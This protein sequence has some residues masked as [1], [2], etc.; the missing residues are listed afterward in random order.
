[1]NL[2]DRAKGRITPGIFRIPGTSTRV[3]SL[4]KFYAQKWERP[5]KTSVKDQKA[6]QGTLLP[7][8]S[9]PSIHDVASAFKKL[10]SG[11][12]GGIL[13]SVELFNTINDI[14]RHVPAASD[15]SQLEHQIDQARL[16]ALALT[17]SQAKERVSVICAVF[18]L[19]TMVAHETA[20]AT[21]LAGNGQQLMNAQALGVVFGPL[22]LGCSMH[23]IDVSTEKQQRA[24]SAAPTTWSK[25]SVK[26]SRT[27]ASGNENLMLQLKRAKLVAG[28][29]QFLITIWT[30]VVEQL[31]AIDPSS[32]ETERYERPSTRRQVRAPDE[33]ASDDASNNTIEFGIAVPKT[34]QRAYAD[35]ASDSETI[36]EHSDENGEI[37]E[38]SYETGDVQSHAEETG[39]VHNYSD[40]SEDVRYHSDESGDVRS[41][42]EET[43]DITGRV[44]YTEHAHGHPCTAFSASPAYYRI[45]SIDLAGEKAS[46]T[47]HGS[48]LAGLDDVTTSVTHLELA[49]PTVINSSPEQLHNKDPHTGDLILDFPNLLNRT[50]KEQ[51]PYIHHR[52]SLVKD[53]KTERYGG[54][55][56]PNHINPFPTRDHPGD[57]NK[58]KGR[59]I[60][61]EDMKEE[62]TATT[63]LNQGQLYLE[64]LKRDA[65]GNLYTS[66]E[67]E[68]LALSGNYFYRHIKE[69]LNNSTEYELRRSIT[70]AS[71]TAT[72]TNPSIPPQQEV[73]LHKDC[74]CN[75]PPLWHCRPKEIEV[76]SPRPLRST[77]IV[78]DRIEEMAAS[79]TTATLEVVEAAEATQRRRFAETFAPDFPEGAPRHGGQP[80]KKSRFAA[81]FKVAED[82][83]ASVAA[84]KAEIRKL[85]EGL[86]A[87][88]TLL[89]TMM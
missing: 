80:A 18:G 63:G 11:L 26:P 24:S 25:S 30:N 62:A 37:Q 35:F 31:R 23:Y 69:H 83:A 15:S 86:L 60:E 19:L 44:D 6:I 84:V 77:R 3:N 27:K 9:E 70:G 87:L 85:R 43:G 49:V 29:T 12:P 41:H 50:R 64:S 45:P 33:V 73:N 8:R 71:E 39:G 4:H 66:D 82:K 89:G 68:E 75:E 56:Q 65:F 67:S 34:R 32:T 5:R 79:T 61:S 7:S 2:S 78:V 55:E 54:V 1:M 14:S 81:F 59:A 17:S 76:L 57:L 51:S 42:S 88:E 10:L 74:E 47:R 22:L 48:P 38:H 52:P 13:G 20:K 28:V 21:A 46:L 72:I 40:A 16:I 36:H 58:G 53:V